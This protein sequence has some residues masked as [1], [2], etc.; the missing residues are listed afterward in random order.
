MGSILYLLAVPMYIL[1]GWNLHVVII[2]TSVAIIIYS[3]LGGLKAVI[4]ADAIRE[5]S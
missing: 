1:M 5:S 3:M 4:W 2:T